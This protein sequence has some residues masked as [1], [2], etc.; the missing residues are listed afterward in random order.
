MTTKEWLNRGFD[1][2][3]R[4]QI[5]KAHLETLDNVVSRY[6]AREIEV[7]HAENVSETTFIK[8]SETKKEVEEMERRLDAIDT[9]TKDAIHLLSNP[10][11]FAV[12]YCRYI[13]R[14]SWDDVA[15]ICNY[16]KRSVFRFHADGINHL[17]CLIYSKLC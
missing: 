5:K 2:W 7:Y 10:N 16:S 11:E 14:K 15:E 13:M 17:G 6:D 12:L 3:R 4:L 9:E 1:I 8:W